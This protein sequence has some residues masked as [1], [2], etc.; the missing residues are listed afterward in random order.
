MTAF[1]ATVSQVCVV[2]VCVRACVFVCVCDGM[3]WVVSN[4]GE[5]LT[6]FI[7]I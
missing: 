7:Y 1:L 3:G 5:C 6:L 4:S 2:C